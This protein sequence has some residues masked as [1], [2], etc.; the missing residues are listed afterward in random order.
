M[1][2]KKTAPTTQKLTTLEELAVG[3]KVAGTRRNGLVRGWQAVD[4]EII[5]MVRAKD[6]R[7]IGEINEALKARFS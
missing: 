3:T 4:E 5:T 6:D 1:A 2:T 7:R